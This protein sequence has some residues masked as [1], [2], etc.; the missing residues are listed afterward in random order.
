MKTDTYISR[1][2][3][4]L[5]R[6]FAASMSYA[7]DRAIDRVSDHRVRLF[8]RPQIDTSC[9]NVD[10]ELANR[11]GVNLLIMGPSAATRRVVDRLRP[12]LRGPVVAVRPGQTT[13]LMRGDALGTL[14]LD[15]IEAYGLNEQRHILA[16]LESGNDRPRVI[17]TAS[18]AI[19]P[20]INRGL[21]LEDLYYRLN[22]VCV[23]MRG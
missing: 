3:T 14:V 19:V 5:L 4:D 2:A 22:T 23:E 1:S 18:R 12:S 11:A 16:R 8:S 21:F 15:N 6:E 20:L 17:S 10:C 7:V 9:I 13:V